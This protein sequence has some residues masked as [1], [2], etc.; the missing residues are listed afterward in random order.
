MA[1][2]YKRQDITSTLMPLSA[3]MRD[4]AETP[5]SGSLLRITT[6]S[7]AIPETS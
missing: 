5:Y 4:G 1:V 6:T 3:W 7:T 2:V